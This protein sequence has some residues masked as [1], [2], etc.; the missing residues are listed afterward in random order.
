MAAPVLDDYQFQFGDTGVLLNADSNIAPFVDVMDVAGLDSAAYRTSTKDIEGFDGS[1]IESEFESKR[2]VVLS[3]F[4]YGHAHDIMEQY[5]DL[6]KENLA[7]SKTYTPFYFKVPGRPQR[8]LWA[9]STSGLRCS[10]SSMRRVAI[11]EFQFV[12][13]CGDPIIYGV[14]ETLWSGEIITQPIPGFSF[15]FG[16]NFDFGAISP[17]VTGA[18]NVSHGGNRPAPFIAT[19]TGSG[20]TGPGLKHEVL[21][22]QVEFDVSLEMGD[23]LVVDFRKRTVMLNGSPRRGSVTREGWFLLQ[24]NVANPLRLLTNSGSLQVSISTHD[25]WR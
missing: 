11:G 8:M 13:E 24:Q 10:W 22:R 21:N 19:F 18:M 9:K 20:V 7:P 23:Q 17:G 2:T 6:L 16:F 3:G 25:A 12:L 5:I 14:D 1:V 4:I 15:N